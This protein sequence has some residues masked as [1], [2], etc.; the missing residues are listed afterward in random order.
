M[1]NDVYGSG[2]CELPLLLSG[3]GTE[4]EQRVERT[5]RI[6]LFLTWTVSEGP[7]GTGVS[8]VGPP[9]AQVLRSPPGAGHTVDLAAGWVCPTAIGARMFCRSI[10]Q[11]ASTT[12]R[13]RAKGR[14]E[15]IAN[16]IRPSRARASIVLPSARQLTSTIACIPASRCSAMWQ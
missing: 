8:P 4:N 14:R 12:V 3:T 13:A 10:E 6:V 5:C 2:S 1:G 16:N 9:G 11:P 15:D 7:R